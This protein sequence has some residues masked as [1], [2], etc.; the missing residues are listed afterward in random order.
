L[1]AGPQRIPRGCKAEN[2][3]VWD[4]MVGEGKIIA[5]DCIRNGV[6]VSWHVTNMNIKRTIDARIDGGNEDRVVGRSCM[7]GVEH[8]DGVQVVSPD[9]QPIKF[10]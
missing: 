9:Q 1:R 6:I 10:R 5:R 8:V 3:K 7:E 4:K 2:G